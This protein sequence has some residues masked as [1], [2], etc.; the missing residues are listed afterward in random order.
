[1]SSIDIIIQTIIIISITLSQPLYL[2]VLRIAF[3]KTTLSTP[4]F[5]LLYHRLSSPNF[6]DILFSNL[7]FFK[8]SQLEFLFLGLELS[9]I[10][11]FDTKVIFWRG[12]SWHTLS[13]DEY[14][15]IKDAI[16]KFA[17]K[18]RTSLGGSC[19]DT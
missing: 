16:P 6:H 10:C 19:P 12:T 3:L 17:L 4:F 14:K 15:R 5:L 1:M 11:Q 8:S 9:S 7:F 18:V 13:D 2:V